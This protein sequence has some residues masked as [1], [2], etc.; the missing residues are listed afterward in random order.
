MPTN[1]TNVVLIDEE[2]EQEAES[3]Q[4]LRHVINI[5]FPLYKN[6]YGQTEIA[7]SSLYCHTKHL[8]IAVRA[9]STLGQILIC[10]L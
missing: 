1:N 10:V 6:V 5:Y 4:E 3:E 7:I 2:R 9:S 8:Q